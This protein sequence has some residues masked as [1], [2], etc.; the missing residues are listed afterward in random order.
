MARAEQV[1]VEAPGP[2]DF[3][4]VVAQVT[5]AVVSVQVK[6][7]VAAVANRMMEGFDDLP[8]GMEEF[9]RRFGIPRGFGDNNDDNGARPYQ[10]R[11]GISQGSGFFIS[12]D[13]YLVT[14]AHV[15]QDGTEYTVIMNDGRELGAKVIGT[16][17][18][19]DLALLKVDG[20]DFTFVTFAQEEPKVGQW[21]LAMGNPF[22]L[23]GSVSAGIISAAH[24]D[25]GSGPY[26]NYL[27]IDA[28]VNRGNSGGPA[29]NARGEVVGVNTA[30]FSP[31]GGSVGIAFAIPAN[32]VSDVVDDLRDDGI[33]TRG[34]LGVQIQPVTKDI[35]ESL[36]IEGTEGAIV[37][38]ALASSPAR[39]AGVQTGDVITKVN[40]E[41]IEDP[42]A[43]S[44][45]IA[46]MDPGQ[47]ITVTVLRDGRSQ[48][49]DVTLGDL[50][51]FDV[52]QQASTEEES[53][54][55]AQPAQPGSL[56]D[57]GLT[58]EAN[59]NGEGVLVSGVEDGSLAAERGIQAGSVIVEVGGQAVSSPT[60][61]DEAIAA[62]RDRGREA[63][64][65]RV[66]SEDG[67]RFVG[68]PF[69]RG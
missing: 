34:W 17:D 45:M 19:T 9:F 13:G 1:R 3:T 30:I 35:A 61:V 15:V 47:K 42:K 69:E 63:V 37:A 32:I 16:D 58:L 11:R 25:I 12:Q 54:D 56:E 7:E 59:P 62:A 68:V 14:N 2:A 41:T 44:Q 23:G 28:P 33:V 27:Q 51:Q 46:G 10:P 50:N 6:T 40:G 39:D 4:E 49:I 48:D 67:T 29:F 8:P 52:Q 57:L 36:G 53:Q 22:G 31:S 55:N 5:P 43:L 24:R 20:N 38:D 66:Q 21:V 26:D 64:L 65:L 60:D 18:R